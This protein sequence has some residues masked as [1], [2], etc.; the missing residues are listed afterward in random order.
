MDQNVNF[1]NNFIPVFDKLFISPISDNGDVY[2]KYRVLDSQFVAGRRLIH[3]TFTPKR[4]GE[5][6]FEGDCWVHDSTFAV[7]KMNLRLSKEANINFVDKLS[8]I[9]E[10]RLINDSTWFLAKD[11]FVVDISPLGGS[12]LSFI[13]RKTTTYK[14]IVVNDT[15]VTNELAKNKLLEETI[16]PPAAKNQSDSFWMQARH[17]ELTKTEEGVYKMVD[18]LLQLP[19]FKRARNTVYFITVGYKNIGNY[20]IGPLVQ[21]A[22]L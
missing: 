4:K 20:E 13:G 1:Y 3:L 19:A 21:L 17:E 8:L 7:Q 2:Y 10:Y 12:K 11:K 16:M 5:N 9:Q 22:H 14:D 18:T 15:S 6:T